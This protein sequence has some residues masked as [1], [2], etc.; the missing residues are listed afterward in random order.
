LTDETDELDRVSRLSDDVVAGLREQA[1]D[2]LAKQQ[3]IVG[4][5]HGPPGRSCRL[6]VQ[7]RSMR[8][9]ACRP[10][11]GLRLP[12]RG[13]A[14]LNPPDADA[15]PARLGPRSRPPRTSAGFCGRMRQ[16]DMPAD[17][18]PAK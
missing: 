7:G 8:N 15:V 16:P 4:D 10:T 5:D 2:P 18:A 11:L 1:R 6:P 13:G 3:I 12:A 9:A 17:A 14:A